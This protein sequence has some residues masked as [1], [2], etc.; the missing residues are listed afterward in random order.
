MLML[1][2][3]GT[4]QEGATVTATGVEFDPLELRITLDPACVEA[5]VETA[6]AA[7]PR[8]WVLLA[9]LIALVVAPGGGLL[10]HLPTCAA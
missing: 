2:V 4:T 8:P 9:A 3:T 1:D 10:A 7:S 5:T 6:S